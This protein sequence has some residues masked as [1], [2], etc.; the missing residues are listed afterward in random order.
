MVA[1]VLRLILAAALLLVFAVCVFGLLASFEPP[2]YLFCRSVYSVL[3]ILSGVSMVQL[4]KPAEQ[5]V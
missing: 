5:R 3:I 4:V 2:D 1:F